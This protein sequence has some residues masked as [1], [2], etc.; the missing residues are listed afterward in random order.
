MAPLKSAVTLLAETS[1]SLRSG[2][3]T[4][5]IVVPTKVESGLRGSPAERVMSWAVVDGRR[6]L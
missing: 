6:L 3:S 1:Q 5:K 4:A 2:W